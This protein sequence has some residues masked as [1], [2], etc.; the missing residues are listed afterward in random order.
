MGIRSTRSLF[1]STM[2][3][4]SPPCQGHFF[5]GTDPLFVQILEPVVGS[6]FGIG[7]LECID[8]RRASGCRTRDPRRIHSQESPGRLLVT[9]SSIDYPE[10]VSTNS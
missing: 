10:V 6:Q 2:S 4:E 3:L 8:Q 1:S 9:L 7:L 5:L